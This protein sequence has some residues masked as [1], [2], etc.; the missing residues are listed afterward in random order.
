MAVSTAP[1][2]VAESD[3]AKLANAKQ[4]AAAIQKEINELKANKAENERLKSAIEEQ[5]ANTQAQID[6]VSAALEEIESELDVLQADLDEKNAKLEENKRLFKQRLRAIYMS[7]GASPGIQVLLGGD[8]M[9]DYLA[10]AE[11]A[12]SVSEHDSQLIEEI[13]S[14]VSEVE[15]NVEVVKSKKSE[16]DVAKRNLADAR[17]ALDAQIS[18]YNSI[19]SGIET[20]TEEKQDSLDEYNAAI[21][22]L[23]DKIAA[24]SGNIGNIQFN[25]GQFLWPVPSYFYVSSGFGWRWGRQHKGIDIAGSGIS[26]KAIVASADGQVSLA[27]YNAGGYGNYVMINHGTSGGNS[28]VTLYGHMTRYI[29]SPG[30]TVSKGQTIGYVGSTGASTGPHLHFEIRVN[31]TAV[32]PLTYY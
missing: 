28:Y 3:S 19:I 13:V 29:V 17:A 16:Q 25:G 1:V 21:S 12:R 15:K 26:G 5:V 30:Q 4:Q 27:S 20:Q 14:I 11:L 24:A 18:E 31:G 9:A 23:E 7:S 6:L 10:K 8:D 2:A 32:N 22:D